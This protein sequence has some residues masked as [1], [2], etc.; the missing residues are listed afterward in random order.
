M[1][2][3]GP[4]QR[5]VIATL[6]EMGYPR[7]RNIVLSP[8]RRMSRIHLPAWLKDLDRPECVVSDAHWLWRVYCAEWERTDSFSPKTRREKLRLWNRHRRTLP[9]WPSDA[10]TIGSTPPEEASPPP[11]VFLDPRYVSLDPYIRFFAAVRWTDHDRVLDLFLN[12]HRYI[13]TCSD[14]RHGTIMAS[15]LRPLPRG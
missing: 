5:V 9:H 14:A 15:Y 12:L 6:T 13:Q 8:Q 1:C 7:V 3:P 11:P 4:P 2:S 10:P